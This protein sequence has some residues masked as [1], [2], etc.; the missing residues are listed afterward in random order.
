M[1][2]FDFHVYHMGRLWDMRKFD[3]IRDYRQHQCVAYNIAASFMSA[4]S[5]IVTGSEDGHLVVYDTQ[6]GDVLLRAPTPAGAGS[7]G[8]GEPAI[9]LCAPRPHSPEVA[10]CSV[11]DAHVVVWTASFLPEEEDDPDSEVI[12]TQTSSA[13]VSLV[14]TATESLMGLYGD[15]VLQ[16]RDYLFCLA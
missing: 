6:S 1:M 15:R 8:M 16:V 14:R 9:H 13:N 5:H 3:M 4:G 7:S 12:E 11:L 2:F 10:T